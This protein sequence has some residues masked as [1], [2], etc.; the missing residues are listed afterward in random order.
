M[1]K[2][3]IKSYLST[4]FWH[5]YRFW[6]NEFV[7]Y[8]AILSQFLQKIGYF[9]LDIR[10][11]YNPVKMYV[12]FIRPSASIPEIRNFSSNTTIFG[13][14]QSIIVP[15]TRLCQLAAFDFD[16]LSLRATRKG[17]GISHLRV[18]GACEK[19]SISVR[20]KYTLKSEI[21][22]NITF[23]SLY[24]NTIGIDFWD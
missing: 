21:N 23:T 4:V 18:P 17:K 6:D 12:I 1:A 19:M 15:Y 14:N 20:V 10:N 9:R 22:N 7:S 24:V 13:F 5:T 2:Y 8:L 3:E 11:V 16:H